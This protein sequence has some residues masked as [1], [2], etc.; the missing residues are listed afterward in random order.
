VYLL[1]AK[2]I[3]KL[4]GDILVSIVRPPF[5]GPVACAGL[6]AAGYSGSGTRYWLV[7]RS[8]LAQDGLTPAELGLWQT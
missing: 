8:P 6:V 5:S 7:P 4:L 1:V 3:T 2:L